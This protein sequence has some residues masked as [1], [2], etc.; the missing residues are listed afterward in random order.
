MERSS[1]LVGRLSGLATIVAGVLW[2]V[3]GSTSLNTESLGITKRGPHLLITL[4]ALC[5]LVGVARLASGARDYGRAGTAGAI[6]T[7]AGLVLVI[8][9]KNVPS[10]ISE[11]AAWNVFYLGGTLL[12]LGSLLI[13][14]VVLR[15][16]KDWLVGAPLLAI[17]VFGTLMVVLLMGPFAES[18]LSTIVFPILFGLAWTVLGY[19]L[20]SYEAKP[21]GDPRAAQVREGARREVVSKTAET[22]SSP[23]SKVLKD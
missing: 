11:E 16:S 20:W 6:V 18:A 21:S 3:G 1:A 4:A 17:G 2:T 5:S 12:V 9:S 15:T 8:A 22:L 10:S 13:G 19:A 14:V 7:T 23:S